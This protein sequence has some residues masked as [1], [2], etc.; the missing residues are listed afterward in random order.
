MSSF[1]QPYTSLALQQAL[2]S[3][4]GTQYNRAV[5]DLYQVYYDKISQYL[6]KK[7]VDEADAKDVFQDAVLLFTQRLQNGKIQLNANLGGYLFTICKHLA[8]RQ[9]EQKD[10]MPFVKI[11][12]YIKDRVSGKNSDVR[13][14]DPEWEKLYKRCWEVLDEMGNPCKELILRSLAREEKI[15]DFFAEL[16]YK[17]AQ[18][19]RT[20]KYKYLKRLRV[21]LEKDPEANY[22]MHRLFS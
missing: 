9:K 12:W 18:V 6:L 7:G 10:R 22:L 1:N 20:A 3:S 16:G 14:V 5:R 13:K 11:D 17:N 21:K 2:E 8:I 15:V 19:A 4:D